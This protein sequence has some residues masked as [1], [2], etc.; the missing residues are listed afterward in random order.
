MNAKTILLFAV[1]ALS[2]RAITIVHYSVS[3]NFVE[4][5][6]GNPWLLT[7]DQYP[8]TD[9]FLSLSFVLP[10]GGGAAD[11]AVWNRYAKMVVTANGITHEWEGA[12][13]LHTQRGG[14]GFG[15]GSA[16]ILLG[17]LGYAFQAND[18]NFF[19][20]A[21]PTNFLRLIDG[22]SDL[23]YGGTFSDGALA[24]DLSIEESPNRVSD[25]GSTLALLAFALAGVATSWRRRWVG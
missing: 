25:A 5:A 19:T 9:F 18:T 20:S 14:P 7:Q 12:A 4:V 17:G 21:N 13:E 24:Y 10:E 2:S 16:S 15:N 8:D 11:E 6:A 22:K 3:G 23:A 1:L